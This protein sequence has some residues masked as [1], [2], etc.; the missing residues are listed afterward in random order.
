MEAAKEYTREHHDDGNGPQRTGTDSAK[1]RGGQ[2]A[3]FSWEASP[4][5]TF[6][7]G[8]AE[9]SISVQGGKDKI[10][11]KTMTETTTTKDNDERTNQ[12][13]TTTRTTT[14]H[15]MQEERS[16][17]VYPE[18][19]QETLTK[20]KARAAVWKSAPVSTIKG[21]ERFLW[22]HDVPPAERWLTF[23]QATSH[24]SSATKASYWQSYM[25]T[26]KIMTDQHANAEEKAISRRLEGLAK[27]TQGPRPVRPMSQ[28]E[29]MKIM[30]QPNSRLRTMIGL[31]YVAGQ[32][33]SDVAQL[34][35]GDF[36]LKPGRILITFFRG[37]V[38][39]RIGPYTISIPMEGGHNGS[40]LVAR[41]IIVLLRETPAG[42]ILTKN[43]TE[44]ERATVAE[45]VAAELKMIASDLEVKSIRKGG[46]IR[47]AQGGA[48]IE[49][50]LLFSKH[51]TVSMLYRYLEWG[52]AAT[53][54]HDR[55]DE[56]QRR[57]EMSA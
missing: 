4:Q 19:S 41:R 54:H 44:S 38:I 28:T 18:A 8:R 32:R 22:L 15:I 6:L 2:T 46:L 23:E 37:K 34:Q 17:R 36:V 21:Q 31:S 16:A 11:R 35:T 40:C 1:K 29:Y 47:L 39:P 55:Q 27:T 45:A 3:S 14:I 7:I 10:N 56:A 51:A 49:S 33:M 57:A 25:S 26:V 30:E 48:P 9:Q 13:L 53:E 52:R 5:Q 12:I 43:N 50:V 20:W 24:V 42:F